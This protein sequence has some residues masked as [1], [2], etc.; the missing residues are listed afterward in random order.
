MKRIE[1]VIVFF[2]RV[3]ALLSLGQSS[4]IYFEIKSI[5]GTYLAMS[6]MLSLGAAVYLAIIGGISVAL[7]IIFRKPWTIIAGLSGAVLAGRYARLIFAVRANFEKAFGPG[8]E[9]KISPEM[10]GR[11]LRRR[12]NW[13]LPQEPEPRWE[14]NLAFWTIP[15]SDRKLLCDLWQPPETVPSSGL[16][17]IYFHGSAWCYLDKDVGTRTHFRHLASQGHVVMDVAYRLCPETNLAGMVGDVK[18]AVA[19]MKQNAA[20]FGVN[21]ERIVLAGS[22]AG[23]HLALLSAYTPDHPELTPQ[24]LKEAN[25]EVRGVV[26]FYGP[27]DLRVLA[28]HTGAKLTIDVSETTKKTTEAALNF[29]NKLVR[30]EF[31]ADGSEVNLPGTYYTYSEIMRFLLGGSPEEVPEMY[32]LACPTNHVRPDC[33]PT[34]L[35]HG[36]ADFLAPAEPTR[37]LYQ[38]LVETGIPALC[39]EYPYTDHAFELILPKISPSA[40]SAFYDL[41]RFL[42]LMLGRKETIHE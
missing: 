40:Q 42:G 28:D 9:Q 30:R 34:M 25:T 5:R 11:M 6:R 10:A 7:G 29:T 8:W 33:P 39:V 35:F 3:L 32:D 4:L 20:R 24:E 26:S 19:W 17:Y 27:T 1:A 16:A 41:D 22:S 23:G 13:K 18:R 2:S 31:G 38:K 36:D 12:W 14:R 15:G 37:T 21:P